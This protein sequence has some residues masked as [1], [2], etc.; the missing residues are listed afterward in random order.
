MQ[1]TY[2]CSHRQDYHE[3]NH[4]VDELFHRDKSRKTLHY[5]IG[6]DLFPRIL[7]PPRLA[8]RELASADSPP[9]YSLIVQKSL[10]S[11]FLLPHPQD[12]PAQ[13]LLSHV[14]PPTRR[15]AN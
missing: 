11:P 2:C 6:I 14:N 8:E 15:T 5:W 1:S 7:E 9:F 13:S 12:V 4:S 3:I 10:R